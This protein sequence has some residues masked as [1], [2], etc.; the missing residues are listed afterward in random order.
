MPTATIKRVRL[1]VF[2]TVL[3]YCLPA[4]ARL[5]WHATS[6]VA[7]PEE[8]THL[9]P[10]LFNRAL[11]DMFSETRSE[12]VSQSPDGSDKCLGKRANRIESR[13]LLRQALSHKLELEIADHEASL[14]L[15]TASATDATAEEEG[16]KLPARRHVLI[17][18]FTTLLRRLDT[19]SF[20]SADLVGM[21]YSSDMAGIIEARRGAA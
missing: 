6:P 21:A 16:R 8:G 3:T 19:S 14:E 1:A 7:R 20:M 11:K 12:L 17:R 5:L 9:S 2:P 4:S 10:D 13:L 18:E 15:E